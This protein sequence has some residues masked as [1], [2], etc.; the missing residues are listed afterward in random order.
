MMGC[1]LSGGRWQQ[2]GDVV[3]GNRLH[4]VILGLLAGESLFTD[5]I[6]AL[7]ASRYPQCGPV[8][9][10]GIQD[11]VNNLLSQGLATQQHEDGRVKLT[12]SESGQ[13]WVAANQH[14]LARYQW[15]IG[16]SAPRGGTGLIG[17]MD[18]LKSALG[19]KKQQLLSE[20]QLQQM[21]DVIE[22]AAQQIA[23]I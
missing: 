18:K 4:L 14:K 12:I 2:G 7:L 1:R 22:G 16:L 6:P 19:L 9:Q 5:Q 21:V 3:S 10:G 17:A 11:N 23:K 15:G 20:A 13:Q 8:Q